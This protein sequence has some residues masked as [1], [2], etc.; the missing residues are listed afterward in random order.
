MLFSRKSAYCLL[1]FFV[2]LAF[3]IFNI[4][5]A[6]CMYIKSDNL[7]QLT[8]GNFLT[9]PLHN[10]HQC[11]NKILVEILRGLDLDNKHTFYL[12]ELCIMDQSLTW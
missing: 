4:I 2:N 10:I 12:G 5:M 11:Y 3:L 8:L 6:I 7:N 1:T 9:F